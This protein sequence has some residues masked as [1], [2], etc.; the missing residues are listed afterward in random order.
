M[1]IDEILG[2]IRRLSEV[3]QRELLELLAAELGS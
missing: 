3:R 1:S 2:R